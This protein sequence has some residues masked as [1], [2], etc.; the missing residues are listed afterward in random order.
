MP[1]IILNVAP[2]YLFHI[3]WRKTYNW[4]QEASLD[5][6]EM[7]LKYFVATRSPSKLLTKLK[8]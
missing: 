3:I 2:I 8:N 4:E 1:K 7:N 6:N 5:Q